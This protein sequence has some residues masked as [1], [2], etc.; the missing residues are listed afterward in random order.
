MTK[1]KRASEVPV[2]QVKITLLGV[3]PPI[4]RRFL[5]RSDVTLPR[6][7]RILQDV[8]GWTDSHLHEL[9]VGGQS[10]GMPDPDYPDDMH[11]ERW[12]RLS[13]L[14]MDKGAEL[15][16]I[17]DFGDFWEHCL[18]VE[19]VLPPDAGLGLARCVGGERACPPEDVGGVP[20]YSEFC[21]AVKDPAHEDHEELLEWVGGEYDGEYFD[22]DGINWMLLRYLMWSRDRHLDWGPIE[23]YE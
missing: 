23:W 17:Y 13:R 2:Y 8:M 7:H 5:V 20:G 1:S 18:V 21:R 10:Y 3:S 14:A 4:W 16:Y 12:V 15:R 11:D 22:R 9:I 19:E 6:L